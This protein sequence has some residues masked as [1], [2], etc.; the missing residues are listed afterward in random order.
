MLTHKY[1]KFLPKNNYVC[2]SVWVIDPIDTTQGN[3]PVLIHQKPDMVNFNNIQ[4][5]KHATEADISD[6]HR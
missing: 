4:L 3:E 6:E 1:Q 2:E 5:K